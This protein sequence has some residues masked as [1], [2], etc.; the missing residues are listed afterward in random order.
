L[1]EAISQEDCSQEAR[2]AAAAAESKA[3]EEELAELQARVAEVT[4][5]IAEKKKASFKPGSV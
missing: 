5:R 3:D 2:A 1:T 4:A